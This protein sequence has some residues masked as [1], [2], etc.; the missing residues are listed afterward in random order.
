MEGYSR[1][2]SSP[3]GLHV[4]GQYGEGEMI[5]FLE[6]MLVRKIEVT[7]QFN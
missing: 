7:V 2:N 6:E 5:I 3:Y 4:F 1:R